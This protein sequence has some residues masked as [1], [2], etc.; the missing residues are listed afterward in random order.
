MLL[1]TP[2]REHLFDVSVFHGD[3]LYFPYISVFVV[4]V[5]PTFPAKTWVSMHEGAWIDNAYSFV[6][7]TNDILTLT[8]IHRFIFSAYKADLYVIGSE[9][10]AGISMPNLSHAHLSYW[11][12][13]FGL[14]REVH[15][16]VLTY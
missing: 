2:K 4:A 3:I 10:Y 13:P 14:D 1:I 9:Y 8:A 15:K 7:S 11:L 5:S 6:F 16:H 12:R